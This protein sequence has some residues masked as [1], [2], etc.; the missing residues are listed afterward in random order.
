MADWCVPALEPSKFLLIGRFRAY[1]L[2]KRH[3]GV[4]LHTL[5]YSGS[6]KSKVQHFNFNSANLLLLLY[7]NDP[8]RVRSRGTVFLL[9]A[10]P[11]Q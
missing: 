11:L 6:A 5:Y 1:K 7:G 3:F 8:V 10:A 4:Q 9:I 2:S